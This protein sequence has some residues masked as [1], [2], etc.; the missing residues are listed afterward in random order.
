M[1]IPYLTSVDFGQNEIL[2]ARVQNLGTAPVS[3]VTG[4]IYYDTGTNLINVWDGSQWLEL[5]AVPPGGTGTVDS[6]SAGVGITVSGTNNVVVTH[7]TPANVATDSSNSG[8][9]YIQSLTFDQFG[10]VESVATDTITLADLGG[11]NYGS[12][13]ISDGTNTEAIA[14][15][16]SLI[17]SGTGTVTSSYNAATNTLTINGTTD[18]TVTSVGVSG[19]DGIEVDSGSPITSSG[20]ITLGINASTLRTHLNVAN[21]AE[22][23]QNAFSSVAVPGQ[24]TVSADSKTDTV[25]FSPGSNVTITTNATTDVVTI[26]STDTTYTASNGVNISGIDI[27]LTGQASALHNLGVSGLIARTGAGTI[28]ARSITAGS[29]MTITNGDGVSGNPTIINNDRGSSQNIFKNISADSGSATANTN[30]DTLTFTGGEGITTAASDISNNADISIDVD[31]TVVRTTAIDQIIGGNKKFTGTTTFE[32]DIVQSGAYTLTAPTIVNTED[33]LLFLNSNY[34]NIA[35]ADD[36]GFLI[37][38]GSSN[39]AGLIFD[40]SDD[41]FAT[42]YTT[43]NGTG[44]V[45]TGIVIT[46]YADFIAG[47]LF[48]A[49]TAAMSTT[50]NEF[51]VLDNEEIKFR[52]ASQLR[53]DIGAG[54]AES[55][56]ITPGVGINV[57]DNT[58]GNNYIFEITA[59]DAT[60]TAKGISELAT[61]T[62]TRAMS[63]TVRTV[64]PSGL[65]GLRHSEDIGG[66][67]SINVTHN[68]GTKDVIVQLY[69]NSTGETVYADITR[70]S[71]SVVNV[72]FSSAPAANAIRILIIKV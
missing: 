45:G 38:R 8:T 10:H 36:T 5:T 34:A 29:G 28:A 18:G 56:T 52:T 6:V 71:T 46:S 59:T 61:L 67:T 2:N 72:G 24:T 41:K 58:A 32:G 9:T 60:T 1:P 30:S 12:W 4:Q 70:T 11:D 13:T 68:L 37:N 16:Q 63:D 49:N 20:T 69:D 7:A 21:G 31:S 54:T 3:G 51:L 62:E 53:S 48:I 40:E 44:G 39:N 65:K 57:T 64:T 33:N 27:Q 15:G 43:D 50:P 23:N 35:P 22:V 66:A 14:S 47:K 25:T 17:I 55:V 26:S 19:S 42:V